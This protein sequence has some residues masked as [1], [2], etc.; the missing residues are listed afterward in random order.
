[1]STPTSRAIARVARDPVTPAARCPACRGLHWMRLPDG[2]WFRFDAE[3]DAWL[4]LEP[5]A[6]LAVVCGCGRGL[7]AV[8]PGDE[9]VCLRLSALDRALG[10]APV[11]EA[12]A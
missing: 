4:V 3:E 8:G 1:M 11:W 10:T 6:S 5:S 12:P 2:R 9:A 7:V